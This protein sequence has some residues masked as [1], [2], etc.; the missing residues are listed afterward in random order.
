MLSLQC[1]GFS[2]PGLLALSLHYFANAHAS[3]FLEGFTI[4]SWWQ[5]FG[6]LS[7]WGF[8][9]F[10][11][12]QFGYRP[13][14]IN[15]ELLQVPETCSRWEKPIVREAAPGRQVMGWEGPLAW[16]LEGELTTPGESGVPEWHLPGVRMG[17]SLIFE[18]TATSSPLTSSQ[19][20][21]LL[22]S[23]LS[24]PL[25]LLPGVFL[26]FIMLASPFPNWFDPECKECDCCLMLFT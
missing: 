19:S 21:S 9:L 20:S 4:A 12:L 23:D 16:N 8:S 3:R 5:D 2:W 15:E 11:L 18:L 24:P 14:I 10:H 6:V 1:C 22:S 13:L 25:S 26:T 17:A 7:I